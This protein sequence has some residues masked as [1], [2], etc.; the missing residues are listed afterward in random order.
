[1]NLLTDDGRVIKAINKGRNQHQMETVIIEVMQ[2]FADQAS[3]RNI[4]IY[5]SNTQDKL[6]VSSNNDIY[7]FPIN[8]CHLK[9]SCR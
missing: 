1:M 5:R 3:V 2:V 6:I 8:R 4:K 9:T 7:S